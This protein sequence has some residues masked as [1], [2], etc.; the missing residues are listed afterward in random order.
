MGSSFIFGKSMSLTISS[1]SHRNRLMSWPI[2]ENSLLKKQ[3]HWLHWNQRVSEKPMVHSG[4]S[5][6]FE[7]VILVTHCTDLGINKVT[8]W[9]FRNAST[10]TRR[11]TQRRWS[12]RWRP[13]SACG[14]RG[15]PCYRTD[16]TAASSVLSPRSPPPQN[17][18]LLSST[19]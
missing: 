12:F 1:L 17:G 3:I 2:R 11:R 9:Y 8:V 14:S 19:M 10:L 18:S 13:W 4:G 5:G 7:P 6:I 15:S 16:S